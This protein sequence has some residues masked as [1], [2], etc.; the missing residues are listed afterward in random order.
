VPDSVFC[1][2]NLFIGGAKSLD[3]AI[4]LAALALQ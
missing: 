1:H 4:R 2:M 3:G